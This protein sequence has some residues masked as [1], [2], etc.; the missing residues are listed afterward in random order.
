[1]A[2][3]VKMML[4]MMMMITSDKNHN[5][6]VYKK[7]DKEGDEG[8]EGWWGVMGGDEMRCDD[9]WCSLSSGKDLEGLARKAQSLFFLL[10]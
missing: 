10:P 5:D 8:D 1:M 9:R 4:M 2:M 7:R 6:K 3:M